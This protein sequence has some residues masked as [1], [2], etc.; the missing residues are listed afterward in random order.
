MQSMEATLMALAAATA[1]TQS[2]NCV[3]CLDWDGSTLRVRT[4][5]GWS[6]RAYN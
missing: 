4:E 3:P 2:N 6:F 5:A 1:V